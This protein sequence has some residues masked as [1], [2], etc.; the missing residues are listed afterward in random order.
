MDQSIQEIVDTAK[1][2]NTQVSGPI[3][4]PTLVNPTAHVIENIL[5]K[6]KI[7]ILQCIIYIINPTDQTLDD[8]KKLNLPSAVDVQIKL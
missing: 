7:S 3:L 1:R 8:L 6:S 4:L 5:E 2:S